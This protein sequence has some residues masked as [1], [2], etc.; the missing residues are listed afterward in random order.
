MISS[1]SELSRREALLQVLRA[2]ADLDLQA[3]VLIREFVAVQLRNMLPGAR[4]AVVACTATDD[5]ETFTLAT[6]RGTDGSLL[7]SKRDEQSLLGVGDAVRIAEA[8]H[9]IGEAYRMQAEDWLT[10][11]DVADAD[12]P[13]DTAAEC[14]LY[15]DV[16]LL[17]DLEA[18]M[19]DR[20]R[21]LG[22][23]GAPIG[24]PEL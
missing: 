22:E 15:A 21:L 23:E 4:W 16:L 11:A 1:L 3:S 9:L 8:T 6:V 14:A 2:K 12:L 20:R 19:M 18:A 10:V 17:V 24:Q 7:W 5:R 13:Y